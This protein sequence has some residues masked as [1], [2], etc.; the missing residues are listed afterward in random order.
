MSKFLAIDRDKSSSWLHQNAILNQLVHLLSGVASY[1][2]LRNLVP[3][4][5]VSTENETLIAKSFG[6][7]LLNLQVTLVSLMRVVSSYVKFSCLRCFVACAYNFFG[8]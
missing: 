3:E 2:I 7:R 1:R 8:E 6:R 5:V 4:L